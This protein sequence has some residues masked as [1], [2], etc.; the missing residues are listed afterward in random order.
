MRARLSAGAGP[1]RRRVRTYAARHAMLPRGARVVV[2]VSGGVD[3]T[4]LLDLLAAET[5]AGGFEIIAAHV[6]HGLRP[7]SPA[8]AASA[9]EFAARCGVPLHVRHVSVS[10]GAGGRASEAAARVARLAALRAVAADVNADR[11][12]T[13]HTA[14]DQAET[15]V[16]RLA[17]G[18]GPAGLSGIRPN[19]ADEDGLRWVRPLLAE[20]RPE[21]E[22]YARERGLHW[23]EDPT[24]ASATY[25]RNRVRH[26]V[27]PALGEVAGPGV[28][29]R[30]RALGETMDEERD[31]IAWWVDRQ[32][33]NTWALAPD[34]TVTVDVRALQ[35]LPRAFRRHILRHAVRAAGA[36][37]GVYRVHLEALRRLCR[38]TDGSA[39]LDLPGGL[40]ARRT[41]G[42]LALEAARTRMAPG[43]R[44]RVRG[45]ATPWG[46]QRGPQGPPTSTTFRPRRRRPCCE[47]LIL[48]EGLHRF[49]DVSLEV[50]S[51]PAL[52][53]VPRGTATEEWFD[54]RG[55]PF[56]LKLRPAA[57]G[58]RMTRFGT[59][60]QRK[61]S[62]ILVDRKVPRRDRD[63]K[64]LLVDADD[65]LLWLVGVA[66]AAGRPVVPGSGPVLRVRALAGEEAAAIVCGEQNRYGDRRRIPARTLGLEGR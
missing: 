4:V 14:D 38:S 54:G 56:P 63:W 43:S 11:V 9:A 34:G 66:R 61:V 53:E 35:G 10:Q 59:P 25:A 51:L 16:L 1:L 3:S 40:T 26:V 5:K 57:R 8:D 33:G 20:H 41:Y 36:A 44:G 47:H 27:L 39:T 18:V 64:R 29:G 30:L 13:G 46:E 45:E 6:D 37:E 28:A 22:R 50:C 48:G 60:G 42:T 17:R 32:E 2:A 15:I 55:A 19:R 23:V 12:A 24:N 21:I 58:E 52:A 62:R 7:D 65:E 49:E 31:A